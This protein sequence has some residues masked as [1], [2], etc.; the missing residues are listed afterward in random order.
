MTTS[1]NRKNPPARRSSDRSDPQVRLLALVF[2]T[3]DDEVKQGGLKGTAAHKVPPTIAKAVAKMLREIGEDAKLGQDLVVTI[4]PSMQDPAARRQHE[5]FVAH[6]TEHLAQELPDDPL[7]GMTVVVQRR[8]QDIVG[9]E[10]AAVRRRSSSREV[11]AP[12]DPET[13]A[14]PDTTRTVV[15]TRKGTRSTPSSAKG[16][17]V[18]NPSAPVPE[19]PRPRMLG[20]V[21]VKVMAQA[22]PR[23]AASRGP[24]F[25]QFAFL[26]QALE[27]YQIAWAAQKRRPSQELGSDAAREF[28]AQCGDVYRM[29]REEAVAAGVPDASFTVDDMHRILK[30]LVQKLGLVMEVSGGH[31]RLKVQAGRHTGR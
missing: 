1:R 19:P 20:D 9:A 18:V 10:A 7:Q 29:L 27:G 21:F 14:F 15:A 8:A 3:R 31:V 23:L 24:T 26:E 17:W 5:T 12:M 16:R 22:L 4:G 30:A 25:N 2:A 6:L 13:R 28:E 11:P